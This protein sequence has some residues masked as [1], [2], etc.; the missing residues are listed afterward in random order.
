[1]TDDQLITHFQKVED[2]FNR[3]LASNDISDISKY[4]SDDWVLLEP[5][6]GLISKEQFLGAIELGELSHTTMIKKVLRAKLYNEV[7]IVTTRGMNI[8]FL[9]DQPFNSEQWVTNIYKKEN[10]HW[11]CIM[12][13]EAPV[14]CKNL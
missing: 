4:L 13:K 10:E 11:V 1:M 3:A 12:T 7:A 2:N 6:H 5:G 8:G 9:K 14:S